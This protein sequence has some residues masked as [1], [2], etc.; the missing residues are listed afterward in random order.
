ME[1]RGKERWVEGRVER[2]KGNTE[3][4]DEISKEMWREKGT[5]SP[6]SA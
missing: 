5:V 6:S 4:D 2:G 3:T 1:E